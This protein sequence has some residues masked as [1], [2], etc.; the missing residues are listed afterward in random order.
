MTF[1]RWKMNNQK[2]SRFQH[3]LKQIGLFL[4]AALLLPLLFT[5]IPTPGWSNEKAEQKSVTIG[6]Q[7][8]INDDLYL[9]ADTIAI[10]GM[11]KGDAVVA[12]SQITLNGTVEGDLIAAGRIITVNGT[13]KDDIRMVGQVLVLG[14]SARISDDVIA[15]GY[16]LENKKGSAIA[17]NL[18]Y[19]G[20][21]GLFAGTVQQNIR[22]A[23]AAMQIASP[24]KGNVNV[25]VGT[26]KLD[27]PPFIPDAAVIPQIPSGLTI[28][29][30]AQIGGALTY[31]S[32]AE[33]KID[34]GATVAGRVV[35]EGIPSSAKEPTSATYGIFFQLQRLVVLGLVGWLLLRLIPGWTQ[36][37]SATVQSRPLPSFGWGIVSV[38]AVLATAI[39]LS[40][41]TTLL[42]V[43]SG[44]LLPSLALPVLGVGFL[45]F[46]ALLIGFGIAASFV[47]PIVLSFLGGKWLMARF[48]PDRPMEHWMTLCAGLVMFVILTAIPVVGDLLNAIAIVMGLGAIW[49]WWRQGD[50]S[51]TSSEPSLMSAP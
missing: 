37:L 5:L 15:A 20:A 47:P 19:F 45:A 30:A 10:D 18:N 31:H 35:R 29:D 26:H 28:T 23:A 43:I 1:R 40:I 39:A 41:L 46:F 51:R 13:V 7:E 42:L 6:V 44:V 48:R 22:G 2:H 17:G 24:V 25:T 4:V 3:Q 27:R 14:E 11:I 36:T 8:V 49:L 9:V 12:A 16:S 50:R 34:P 33:A 21:Q 32:E 38:A